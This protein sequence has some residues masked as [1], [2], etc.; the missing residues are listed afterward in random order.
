MGYEAHAVFEKPSDENATMWRYMS[1]SKFAWLMQQ[2][3]LYF[4]VLDQLEDVHEATLPWAY[5][6]TWDERIVASF[7][8]ERKASAVN[9]WHLNENESALMWKAYG[10]YKEGIAI[11]S[12]FARLTRAFTDSD[13]NNWS[14]GSPVF[15][16]TVKY[17]DFKNTAKEQLDEIIKRPDNA[18]FPMLYK[19]DYFKHEQEVRAVLSPKP[20]GILYEAFRQD[21]MR[22]IGVP[23]DLDVLIE[24]IYVAPAA[25]DWFYKFVR[26]LVLEKFAVERSGMD[27][28]PPS[29]EGDASE[30]LKG[31]FMYPAPP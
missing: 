29:T 31:K 14:Y 7:H 30:L 15:V 8:Q 9:C 1:F 13:D 26:S 2:S 4:T 19:R 27:D 24:R 12:T 17:I 3:Q 23:V 16:G 22:G 20:G 21:E 28:I 10:S 5:L 6:S 18:F 25:E 11:R